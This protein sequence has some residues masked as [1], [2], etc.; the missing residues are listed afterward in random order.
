MNYVYLGPHTSIA[1]KINDLPNFQSPTVL[2]LHYDLQV[3][4]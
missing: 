2:H 3:Q 1:Q 4:Y